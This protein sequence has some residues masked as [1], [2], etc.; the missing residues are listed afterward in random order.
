VSNAEGGLRKR[1]RS[2]P[3]RPAAGPQPRGPPRRGGRDIISGG[4]PQHDTFGYDL[5]TAEVLVE[6]MNYVEK[7]GRDRHRSGPTPLR[8]DWG[9][10][11]AGLAELGR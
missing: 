5:A 11:E 9:R 1:S 2:S 7:T 6:S 3:E 4:T 8:A 10:L